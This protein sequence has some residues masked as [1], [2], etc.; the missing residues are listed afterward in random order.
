MYTLAVP[1]LL[2]LLLHVPHVRGAGLN[3]DSCTSDSDCIGERKCF[4]ED[5]NFCESLSKLS[6]FCLK[7]DFGPCTSSVVCDTGEICAIT[8]ATDDPETL[9]CLSCAIVTPSYY[10]ADSGNCIP[11]ETDA[12]TQAPQIT[13]ATTTTTT[14]TTPETRPSQPQARP[15][16]TMASNPDL[17]T[18]TFEPGQ[19][20]GISL[21]ICIAVDA[22]SHLP[23]SALVYAEHHLARV[24]C[25]ARRSC[26][27]PGHIVVH[28]DV[29]MMM[30]TYCTA[31][32][33][34]G[35][36]TANMY[37]NNPRMRRRIR[38]PSRTDGL[39]FTA[40]AARFESGIEE[41][42]LAGLVHMGA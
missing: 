20:P 24:L 37:V 16:A 26:A 21:T 35:C 39:E 7:L 10:R 8:S 31:H 13:T 9:F 17:P 40:L 42:V 1:L 38:V 14:T 41:T 15:P 19:E 32:A 6:C 28:H 4:D 12:P 3:V 33:L 29:P 25:D 23:S 34:G 11:E 36:H 18:A 30:A 22:L 2:L 5:M 27:T